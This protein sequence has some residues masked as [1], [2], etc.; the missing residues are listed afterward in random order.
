M[1]LILVAAESFVPSKGGG[2]G[3]YICIILLGKLVFHYFIFINYFRM[4]ENVTTHTH[5]H[6]LFNLEGYHLLEKEMEN[7][8]KNFD[9]RTLAHLKKLMV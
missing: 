6:P 4:G 8:E 9:E 2:F 7:H 3:S 5:I 1:F